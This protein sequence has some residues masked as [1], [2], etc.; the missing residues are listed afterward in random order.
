LKRPWIYLLYLIY[1][2]EAGVYLALV[3]WTAFWV[4]VAF[5]WP[6]RFRLLLLGGTARGSISAFGLLLIVVCAVD[7]ARFCRALRAS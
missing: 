4:P 1:C 3:P 2:A 6:E 7:L 5:G